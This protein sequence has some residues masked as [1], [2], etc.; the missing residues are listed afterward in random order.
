M[1]A[2]SHSFEAIWNKNANPTSTSY[3]VEAISLILQNAEDFKKNPLDLNIRKN[4]LKAANKA[5]L[6]FSNTKTAAAHSISYPLTIHYGIPHGIASSMSLIPLLIINSES[7]QKPLGKI[8]E[9]NVLTFNQ[10]IEK[11]QSIPQGI[12]P[13][14]LGKWGVSEANLD[15]LAS[16]S[17]TKGRMDN[18]VVELSVSDVR[19]ILN[20]IY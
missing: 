1:D 11:I 2:L 14:N 7:I 16:E 6:A 12:I 19:S 9:Q 15:Q 10:F 8:L 20:K 18:N 4:L 17:F 5:G 3:A 13:Y